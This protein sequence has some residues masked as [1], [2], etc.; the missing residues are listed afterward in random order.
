MLKC[1]TRAS[2][3]ASARVEVTRASELASAREE[4]TF[5]SDLVDSVVGVYAFGHAV[6]LLIRR[7]IGRGIY[8][9]TTL[10]RRAA[11]VSCAPPPVPPSSHARRCPRHALR[12][13][14]QASSK[15]WLGVI[16][17]CCNSESREILNCQ[18]SEFQGILNCHDLEFQGILNCHDSEL[19]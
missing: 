18:D 1:V 13:P 6:S 17:D 7:S 3:L 16:C 8:Y 4:D 11:A 15:P 2:E 10:C 9:P 12:R 14:C 19:S 5:E